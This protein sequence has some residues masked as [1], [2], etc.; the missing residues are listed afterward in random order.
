MGDN[1]RDL[2]LFVCTGNTCRSPMAEA[3]AVDYFLRDPER[4]RGL[5]VGSAGVFA[6][7]GA[8]PT[9][10]AVRAV[11]SLGASMP[12][13]ASRPL[14]PDL[15]EAA[16]AIYCMTADHARAVVSLAPH[17][18]D[19]VFVLDPSG[20][21]VPDP[22]G[23]PQSLYDETGRRIRELVRTRLEELTP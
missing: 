1:G 23:G 2:V 18:A 14:S 9:P 11:E 13:R 6:G 4:G 12:K 21:D 16:R 10:E 17:V 8:P 7:S 20:E 15:L 22:L 3:L 5:R 19:R